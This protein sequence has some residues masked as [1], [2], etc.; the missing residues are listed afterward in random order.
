MAF[1][2][3]ARSASP[4]RDDVAE[5]PLWRLHL[6]RVDTSLWTLASRRE[7]AGG[8]YDRSMPLFEGVV[9]VL[10]TA[11]SLLAFLELRY[12]V[13]AAADPAVRV[14]LETHSAGGRSRA[15]CGGP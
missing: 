7:M 8:R 5:L 1:N 2:A 15:C 12:S 6:M 4:A 11:M 9:A 3:T 14:C 10:L 13:S